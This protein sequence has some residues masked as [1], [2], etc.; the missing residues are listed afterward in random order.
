MNI[1]PFL[2]PRLIGDRFEGPAI[3]L[4]FLK[5]FAVL[6]EL[7]IEVAKWRFMK[8]HPGRKRSP[9]GF[10]EGITLKLTGIEKGSAK[11][12]I[13]LLVAASTLF[14]VGNEIYFEEA[15]DAVIRAI[16]AAEKGQSITDHLPEETLGYFDRFGRSLRNGE[17]IEF[18]TPSQAAPVRLTRETRRRL[19]LA[20]SKVKELTE[21]TTVR[22]TVPEADQDKMSFE[23]QLIDG[24][25]VRAP[26]DAQHLDTILEAFA[27]YRSG[28]RILLQ[29]IGTFDR[30]ERLL[31]FASI[32][33]AS[34][35]DP[36]D[37]CARL[38]EL[39]LLKDNWLEGQGR[40]PPPGGIDW[41]SQTLGQRYPDDLALPR[42][43]PTVEGGIQAEWSIEPNEITLQIDLTSH[44]GQWY[45]LNMQ[46]D[47]EETD[48]FNLDDS[49]DWERLITRIRQ[50]TGG[51]S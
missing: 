7:M 41:L 35:L 26:M 20:S 25:K 40:A 19:V 6:E 8:G 31:R 2:E 28:T 24:R 13:D 21:E 27:G 48:A 29:G 15:R 1:Q 11:P 47:L 32:E 30:T 36:L 12:V 10:T 23:V 14:P 22:G 37:I 3:P 42:V 49:K 44:Q 50:T 18:T 51:A 4:E 45:V 43:Y 16:G 5:D 33:H 34:I 38:E 9:R 39:R 17:A 46:T